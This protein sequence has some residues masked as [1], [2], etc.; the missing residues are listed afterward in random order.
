MFLFLT[1]KQKRNIRKGKKSALVGTYQILVM[2][3]KPAFNLKYTPRTQGKTVDLFQIPGMA[4]SLKTNY[5]QLWYMRESGGPKIYSFYVCR[6][7]LIANK[8]EVI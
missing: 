6:R 1:E 4:D 3:S 8:R 5:S 2:C 7:N